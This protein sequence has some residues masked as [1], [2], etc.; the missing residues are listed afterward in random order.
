MQNIRIRSLRVAESCP[1][2]GEGIPILTAFLELT[3]ITVP[4]GAPR[5]RRTSPL[6]SS[7]RYFSF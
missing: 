1:L 3:R 4:R 2:F 5:E 7:L 6:R